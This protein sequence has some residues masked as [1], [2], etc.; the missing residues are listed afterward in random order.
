MYVILAGTAVHDGQILCQLSAVLEMPL[1]K[2]SFLHLRCFAQDVRHQQYTRIFGQYQINLVKSSCFKTV[3]Q[4]KKDKTIYLN[5]NQDV[6]CTN[7][8]HINNKTYVED[9]SCQ[10]STKHELSHV[11]MKSLRSFSFSENVY[12][13]RRIGTWIDSG[14]AV[15]RWLIRC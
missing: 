12:V 13:D 14:W 7:M 5:K 8:I 15:L 3:H 2:T 9:S 1:F 6:I 4:Q 10:K 11:L